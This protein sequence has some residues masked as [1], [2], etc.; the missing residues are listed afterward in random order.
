MVGRPLPSDVDSAFGHLISDPQGVEGTDRVAEQVD[1]GAF[2]RW[3]Q[4][5]FDDLKLQ[6]PQSR[7][8]RAAASPGCRH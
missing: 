5:A 7:S 3:I 8:V 4:L 2:V 6:L 1:P